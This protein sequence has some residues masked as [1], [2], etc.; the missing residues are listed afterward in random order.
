MPLSSNLYAFKVQTLET[1]LAQKAAPKVPE[2]PSYGQFMRGHSKPAFSE[3]VQRGD[4][5]KFFK[6]RQK[7]SPRLKGLIAIWRKWHY[8][9][10]SMHL[11]C[12]DWKRFWLKKRLQR[13]PEW[14]SYNN[15]RKVTQN[16]NFL[17]KCKGRTKGKFSKNRPKS[18][19]RLK[20]LKALWPKW[21]F[22]PISMLLK[23]KDYRRFWCKRRLQK[24]PNNQVMAILARS[25]KTSIFWKSAKGGFKGN[26]SNIPQK[27]AFA[28]EAHKHS[29]T[30]GIIL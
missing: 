21:H 24:C 27:V 10:I 5:G 22:P 29:R 13:V 7:S 8:L 15:F 12:K 30:N 28:L 1:I 20:N 6:N 23:C 9:P 11:K 3:K 26:F 19:D 4:Q 18:S 16:P 17:K 2:L 14:P 25:P